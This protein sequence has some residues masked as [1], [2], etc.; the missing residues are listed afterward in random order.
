MNILERSLV[1]GAMILTVWLLR[2]LLRRRVPERLMLALWAA[3]L[4]RLLIPGGFEVPVPAMSGIIGPDG[5]VRA[6]GMTVQSAAES[7]GEEMLPA[8]AATLSPEPEHVPK[9]S[10]ELIYCAGAGLTALAFSAMY[11]WGRFRLRGAAPVEGAA[12]LRAGRRSVWLY[13][14]K[15]VKSPVSMGLMRPRIILPSGMRPDDPGADMI[16]GHELAHIR[17]FHGLWKAAALAAVCIHWFNPLVWLLRSMIS[18]ELELMADRAA[19]QENGER[20]E[21]Y[22]YLLIRMAGGNAGVAASGFGG[23]RIRE[24]IVSVMKGKKTSV[25]AVLMAA[26]L[27]AASVFAFAEPVSAARQA[28]AGGVS[29]GVSETMTKSEFRKW[30]LLRAGIARHDGNLSEEEFERLEKETLDALL[31]CIEGDQVEMITYHAWGGTE[32]NGAVNVIVG[33]DGTQYIVYASSQPMKTVLGAPVERTETELI[34]LQPQ[35][36]DLPWSA[37]GDEILT[38]SRVMTRDELTKWYLERT[39][40][41]MAAGEMPLE[42]FAL[43]SREGL[44]TLLGCVEGDTVQLTAV[45]IR[46][47][48]VVRAVVHTLKDR[49]GNERLVCVDS[50]PV[51]RSALGGMVEAHGGSVTVEKG[52]EMEAAEPVKVIDLGERKAG[53]EISLVIDNPEKAAVI[54]GIRREGG[55]MTG[56]NLIR[57]DNYTMTVPADGHWEAF[58]IPVDPAADDTVYAALVSAAEK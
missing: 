46:D 13:E 42:D 6:P 47:A 40:L 27:L 23:R 45:T 55:S 33:D 32:L 1:G 25:W 52:L 53:E 14:S 56:M 34:I 28:P 24:R 48:G 21:E 29:E 19:L 3:A 5:A 16:I 51:W 37:E 35:A 26:V 2:R 41:S 15:R 9:I 54:A 44:Q 8:Q 36:A 20:R 39:M 58:V 49:D 38:E 50:Y 30:F 18:R 12:V 31:S 22:A 17:G 7:S 57:E 10:R 4:L 11:L 43:M